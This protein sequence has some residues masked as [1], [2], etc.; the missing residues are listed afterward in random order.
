MD[1][2]PIKKKEEDF[3]LPSMLAQAKTQDKK[4][5]PWLRKKQSTVVSTSEA[6]SKP[7]LE[8]PALERSVTAA[9]KLN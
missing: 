1:S 8:T 6:T 2:E 4:K 3:Q 9:P 7:E 5:A